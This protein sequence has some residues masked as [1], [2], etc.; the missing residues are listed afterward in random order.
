MP[1]IF[2][3]E[4]KEVEVVSIEAGREAFIRLQEMGILPGARLKV[5]V[6]SN[7]PMI[8][9]VGDSKFALGRGI[10]SK[11]IIRE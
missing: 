9:G 10:A 6:N 11:I 3:K 2:V 5:I 8:V 4:S 1:L 7:G